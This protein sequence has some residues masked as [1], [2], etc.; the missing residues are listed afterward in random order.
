MSRLSWSRC[1]KNATSFTGL[2]RG[3][4]DKNEFFFSILNFY[5]L[6]DKTKSIFFCFFFN[7]KQKLL[8]WENTHRNY[9]VEFLNYLLKSR[10]R[11][12]GGF[13]GGGTLT[14]IFDIWC[15]CGTYC[16]IFIAGWLW[17]CGCIVVF[18]IRVTLEQYAWIFFTN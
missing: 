15:W 16:P 14:F 1:V 12:C 7:L 6:P 4:R 18:R 17:C 8:K 5:I 13:T 9:L 3:E 11:L 10:C 2:F